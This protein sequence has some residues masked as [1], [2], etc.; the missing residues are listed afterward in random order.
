MPVTYF[1]DKA[2]LDDPQARRIDEITLSYTF[3]PVD[4]PDAGASGTTN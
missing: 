3:F 4:R 2:I 1:I